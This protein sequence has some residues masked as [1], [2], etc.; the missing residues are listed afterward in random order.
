MFQPVRSTAP[1]WQTLLLLQYHLLS[2]WLSPSNTLQTSTSAHP[3]TPFTRSPSTTRGGS[4]QWLE[5]R[6]EGAGGAQELQGLLLGGLGSE[7][8]DLAAA[9]SAKES[10]FGV[11]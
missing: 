10:H 5:P 9:T 8:E 2:F 7:G 3:P 6:V 1:T 4:A 11:K